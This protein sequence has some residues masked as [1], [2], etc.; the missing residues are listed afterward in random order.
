[1]ASILTTLRVFLSFLYTNGSTTSDLSLS[2]PSHTKYWYPA[3]PETWKPD[4]VKR[5]LDSIDR[6]NPTG[7]RDYAILLLVAKLGIRVGDIKNMKL[8]HLNWRENKIH[9]IQQKTGND[10]SFPI[11]DDIGWAIIDYLKNGRPISNSQ[12]LFL[13]AYAPYEEFGE[14]SNLHNIVEQHFNIG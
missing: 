12:N 8:S 4:D 7:K 13:R 2:V 14:N 10:V 9:F 11:L 5:M 3:V 1:M 6:G